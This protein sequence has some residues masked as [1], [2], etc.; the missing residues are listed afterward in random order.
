MKIFIIHYQN[1]HFKGN[2]CTYYTILDY[3]TFALL[4]Y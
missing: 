1:E 4:Y 2:Y 3:A